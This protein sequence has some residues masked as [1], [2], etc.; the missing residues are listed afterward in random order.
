[1]LPC[2]SV[3]QSGS[4]CVRL[5]SLRENMKHFLSAEHREHALR[6]CRPSTNA[7][8]P[9]VD[10][11][12]INSV[13][14]CINHLSIHMEGASHQKFHSVAQCMRWC[15]HNF[16]RNMPCIT[17]IHH[18]GEYRFS[19]FLVYEESQASPLTRSFFLE[20]VRQ[21]LLVGSSLDFVGQRTLR[22][23]LESVEGHVYRFCEQTLSYGKSLSSFNSTQTVLPN[24][25]A[26]LQKMATTRWDGRSVWE[27]F[28]PA[29]SYRKRFVYQIVQ[30]L[31]SR[32][33]ELFSDDVF[34]CFRLA[35]NE[36]MWLRSCPSTLYVTR[37][38]NTMY[39]FARSVHKQEGLFRFFPQLPQQGGKYLSLGVAI[40]IHEQER[41]RFEFHH[42]LHA[43][44]SIGEDVRIIPHSK[45]CFSWKGARLVYCSLER[46]GCKA[47]LRSDLKDLHSR[48]QDSFRK[49]IEKRVPPTIFPSQ[50]E[51]LYRMAVEMGKSLARREGVR[52]TSAVGKVRFGYQSDMLHFVAVIV[53]PRPLLSVSIPLHMQ[54]QDMPSLYQINLQDFR[55]LEVGVSSA[56]EACIF[57]ID[58][59]SLS[60]LSKEKGYVVDVQK[61]K[62]QL[63]Q[64]L[65]RVLDMEE[66]QGLGE[67]H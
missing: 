51:E 67:S 34:L 1:M 11:D 37:V 58:M 4:I 57:S 39:S 7:I 15:T 41:K 23:Q 64:D 32:H 65:K 49:S 61:A 17:W 10:E 44:E 55:V 24:T 8:N 16:L 36:E 5:F 30:F 29:L 21:S 62:D 19:I 40:V 9:A 2:D 50:H 35:M 28:L 25:V 27:K 12:F 56:R 54:L 18:A 38:V 52:K 63:L 22:F 14:Q 45:L 66:F 33:P 42:L 47:F 60:F 48:F 59:P 53:K 13:E 26:K 6:I 3:A 43:F 20:L 46:K 31:R